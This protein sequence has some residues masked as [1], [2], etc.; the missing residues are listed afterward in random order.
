[1][2]EKV[3]FCQVEKALFHYGIRVLCLGVVL[4]LF[5]CKIRVSL[6]SAFPLSGAG[7]HVSASRRRSGMKNLGCVD[8]YDLKFYSM[9]W[10]IIL[11]GN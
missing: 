8:R 9:P 4:M 2:L 7:V 10:S 6:F 11:V 3:L 1:M 5:H